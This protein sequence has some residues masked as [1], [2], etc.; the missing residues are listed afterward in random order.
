MTFGELKTLVSVWLDDIY[1]G[2]FTESDVERWLNNA[3]IEAQK[4]VIQAFEGQYN[5]VVQTYTVLNQREYQLPEDF[6]KLS[7]LEIV[8]SGSQF[9]NESR[10]RLQKVTQNQQDFFPDQTGTPVAYFFQGNKLILLPCPSQAW[11]LR[12]TYIYRVSDMVNDS[13]EPDIP[14]EYQEYLAV[15]ATLDGFYRDGRDVTPWLD[16]KKYYEEL[17]KRDAEERYI[18]ESRTIVQ[19]RDDD[20][21][22]MY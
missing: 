3:Q 4:M 22:T 11:L 10:S 13:D 12:M 14:V 8:L 9:P 2:Y 5:K 6:K 15:L 21:E 20:S 16:K 17:F 1:F 18:D 19:T 7:R